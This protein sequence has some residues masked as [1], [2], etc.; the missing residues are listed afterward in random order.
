M[1]L[2]DAF[3]PVFALSS[4]FSGQNHQQHDESLVKGGHHHHHH[5][6]HGHHG[7]GHDQP[8]PGHTL[9]KLNDVSRESIYMRDEGIAIDRYGILIEVVFTVQLRAIIFLVLLGGPVP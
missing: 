7:H 6:H 1:I 9:Y 4:W 2:T 3:W 8:F 5:G